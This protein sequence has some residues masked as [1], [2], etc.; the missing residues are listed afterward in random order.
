MIS[1]F[2]HRSRFPWIGHQMGG[3]FTLDPRD[4]AGQRCD[5]IVGTDWEP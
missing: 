2:F 4:R 3:K 1:T 5:G